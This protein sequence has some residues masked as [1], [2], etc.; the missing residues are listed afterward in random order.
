[1]KWTAAAG[2]FARDPSLTERGR[3]SASASGAS[4]FRGQAPQSRPLLAVAVQ[5]CA[6]GLGQFVAVRLEALQEGGIAVRHFDRVTE[7]ADI[8]P[9]GLLLLGGA[10]LRQRRRADAQNDR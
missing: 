1:L 9:A 3:T 10:G 7:F 6:A 4:G 8:G 2:R 5:R